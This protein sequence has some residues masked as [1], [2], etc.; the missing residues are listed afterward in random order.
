[1]AIDK[2]HASPETSQESNIA[3]DEKKINPDDLTVDQIERHVSVAGDGDEY[4]VTAKTWVVVAVGNPTHVGTDKADSTQVLALS[5][6]ISFFVVRTIPLQESNLQSG[7]R[8]FRLSCK[9][10]TDCNFPTGRYPA[11][12]IFRE[13]SQLNLELP[14]TPRGSSQLL[15]SPL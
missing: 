5:Y 9:I 6:A 12:P 11:S 15:R 8:C 3:V 10:L 13:Q 7:Y 1:M 14:R 2:S 4:E